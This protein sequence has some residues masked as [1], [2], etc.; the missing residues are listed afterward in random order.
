M[1][2][3][4]SQC[5]HVRGVCCHKCRAVAIFVWVCANLSS[6]KLACDLS[7]VVDVDVITLDLRFRSV[8]Q[9]L[10]QDLHT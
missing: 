9:F 5:Q 8:D 7:L 1:D 4:A 10:G 6:S 2:Q 3:L